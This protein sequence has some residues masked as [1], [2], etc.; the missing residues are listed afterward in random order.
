VGLRWGRR[1]GERVARLY[2]ALP[3]G[4]RSGTLDRGVDDP[5]HLAAWYFKRALEAEGVL[6]LGELRTR[7]RPLQYADEPKATDSSDPASPL[8]CGSN[9]PATP[10][11]TVIASLEPAPVGNIVTEINLDS[12]NLYAEVLIRQLGRAAGTGSSFC[13]ILQVQTFL[14]EIGLPRTSVEI[15]DGSGLSNYN[16]ATPA[17]LTALLRHAAVAPWAE[18]FRAGLPVGGG[19]VGTLRHRFRG[20][21]LEGKIHAKTGTLNHVD[22]LAGYMEASSGETLVFSIIVNDRPLESSRA[23]RR[24]DTTLLAIAARH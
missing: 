24:I 17:A 3:T 1:R 13:G 6:V 11:R 20:T 8:Q 19:P 18:T 15:A 4:W 7:R 22:A 23:P 12:Q 9:L 14:E 5:A 2:G 21:A 16:R 10:D